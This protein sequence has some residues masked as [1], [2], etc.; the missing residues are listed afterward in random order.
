LALIVRPAI[1]T[2]LLAAHLEAL[3]IAL[4]CL[5]SLGLVGIAV[6]LRSIFTAEQDFVK[7]PSVEVGG[8]ASNPP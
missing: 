2:S 4:L 8:L 3:W 7:P 1:V 5:A 6:R